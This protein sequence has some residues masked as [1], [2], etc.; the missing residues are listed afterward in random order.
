MIF[1][2]GITA[3]G[4]GTLRDMLIGHFPPRMFT[5]Y[6]YLLMAAVC[7]VSLPLIIL[8]LVFR[9]KIMAGVS[10]GGTKG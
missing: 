10:R 7:A 5:N 1:L 3:L 9:K 2:A 4:G 6:H 8:F